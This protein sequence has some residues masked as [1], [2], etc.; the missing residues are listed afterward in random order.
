M[1]P[2]NDGKKSLRAKSRCGWRELYLAVFAHSGEIIA[3]CLTDQ[4]TGDASQLQP[5]L[6]EI[7][8]EIDQLTTGGAHDGHSNLRRGIPSQHRRKDRHSTALERS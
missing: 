4:E 2:A 8:D 3:H 1:V 6:A 7:N 5:L